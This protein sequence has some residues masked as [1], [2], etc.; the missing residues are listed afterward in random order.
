[1]LG[2]LKKDLKSLAQQSRVVLILLVV[3]SLIFILG[4]QEEGGGMVVGMVAM[5]SALLPITALSYDEKAHW[6]RYALTMPVSRNMLVGSKYLLSFL[7]SLACGLLSLAITLL[8][9]AYLWKE[10][11]LISWMM[12][13]VALLLSAIT[14][15]IYFKLGVEKARFVF[16]GVFLTP[17]I[18]LLA[19]SRLN[20]SLPA[21]DPAQI[22]RFLPLFPIAAL[23]LFG[24]SALLSCRI[25]AGKEF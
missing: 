7:I 19:A 13:G 11:L 10:T 24:A 14:Y 20:L 5:M 1:M 23:V 8:S 2:L 17:T 18:V 25:Y 6:D 15:P 21:M 9:E 4:N 3:Y 12:V 22:E 16:M